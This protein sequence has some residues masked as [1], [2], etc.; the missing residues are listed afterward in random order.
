MNLEIL[1]LMVEVLAAEGF[2]LI[3]LL[4]YGTTMMCAF[5]DV[6]KSIAIVKKAM[7][8][9]GNLITKWKYN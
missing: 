3:L 6:H 4:T 1:E 9:S 5:D 8:T 7:T 2:P